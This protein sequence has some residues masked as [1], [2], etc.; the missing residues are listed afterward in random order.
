MPEVRQARSGEGAQQG[1]ADPTTAG[2][3]RPSRDYHYCR[4]YRVGFSPRDRELNLPED[5]PV[6]GAMERRI[7]DFGV[8]DSG[9]SG[10]PGV[11][12]HGYGRTPAGTHEIDPRDSARCCEREQR[13]PREFQLQ[14]FSISFLR[15]SPERCFSRCSWAVLL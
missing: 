9:P 10:H 13:Q 11:R 8:N 14:S 15:R 7:L 3:L 1:A 12:H 4:S 6:S 5:G 2:E